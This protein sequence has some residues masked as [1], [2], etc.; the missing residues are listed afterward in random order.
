MRNT[1]FDAAGL[2][3]LE[4][5]WLSSNNVLFAGSRSQPS[6]LIDSGY[7][8]HSMQT[9]ALVKQALGLRGLDRI[10]NTHLHSDHCGGNAALQLAFDCEIDIP[11][12]EIEKV[13]AWDVGRLT[14]RDTGQHCPKYRRTGSIRDG[15]EI[16]CGKS[17][18]QVISAPGHD[19]E[20]VVLYEPELGILISADALWENGFGVV[21]PELDGESA[22]DEV[23]R[24]LQRLAELRVE[25]VIPGHG[26]PFQGLA[27]AL[28]RAQ[29]RLASFMADPV[30][31]SRYAA[32]VLI[33]FHLLD[34]QEQRLPELV[35]WM[36]STRYL[37]LTHA[38]HFGSSLLSAWYSSLLEEL[39]SSG[40]I[41]I[42]GERVMNA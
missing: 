31:H 15:D 34:V 40:A 1:T 18:W 30:R 16:R 7:C 39:V 23:G 4:R 21:F 37:H 13:D 20:S 19:P 22:F 33:K 11:A 42:D 17:S 25:W 5:G 32:K 9:V 6:V 14:Y 27:P 3:V 24:T 38:M 26:A 8:T 10:V 12:G 2:Q 36:D 41:S 28:D 29:R 35:Q